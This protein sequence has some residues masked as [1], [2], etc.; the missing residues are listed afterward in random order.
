MRAGAGVR[1]AGRP[2]RLESA[3]SCSCWQ[4]SALRRAAA[5]KDLP[6][7]ELLLAR[8]CLAASRHA[9]PGELT[10]RRPGRPASYCEYQASH[11]RPSKGM[12]AS[13]GTQP[14]RAATRHFVDVVE[15][16]GKQSASGA[17]CVTGK[18]LV[19]EERT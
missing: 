2:G 10:D 15:C 12:L 18:P 13:R 5:G 4:G 3:A 8:I 14:R 7:G 1:R 16:G 17:R 9:L 19:K 11:T 6:H